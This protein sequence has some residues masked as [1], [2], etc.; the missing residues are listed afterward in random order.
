[1]LQDITEE[2]Y[3]HSFTE[4]TLQTAYLKTTLQMQ[5]GQYFPMRM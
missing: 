1:M 3:P 4:T 2:Q 5:E